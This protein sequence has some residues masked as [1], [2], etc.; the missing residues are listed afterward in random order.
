M[1][2]I[3]RF[4]EMTSR[5]EPEKA[6]S[7]EGIKSILLSGRAIRYD[8][9][10]LMASVERKNTRRPHLPEFVPLDAAGSDFE[11]ALDELRAEGADI[12][13]DDMGTGGWRLFRY[14]GRRR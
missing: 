8:G 5:R 3:R 12:L 6:G 4:S 11:A 7:V 1:V 13:V 10:R 14:G 2:H 9:E